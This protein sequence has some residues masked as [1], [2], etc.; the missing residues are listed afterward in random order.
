[1]TWCT[2]QKLPCVLS[3]CWSSKYASAAAFYI[4]GVKL[5][6][7]TLTKVSGS[8]YCKLKPLQLLLYICQ[9]PAAGVYD[10]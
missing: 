9:A 2:S 5:L 10:I 7:L 3:I 4:T 6:D 8:L 1:M